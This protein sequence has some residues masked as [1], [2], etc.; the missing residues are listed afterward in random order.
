[1][2]RVAV[3][4]RPAGVPF[5]A[6]WVHHFG[7]GSSPWRHPRWHEIFFALFIEDVHTCLPDSDPFRNS[8]SQW[9]HD[10]LARFLLYKPVLLSRVDTTELASELRPLVLDSLLQS[11]PVS[12]PDD[13]DS[14]GRV[15]P[16]GVGEELGDED[17]GS[18][19]ASSD[20]DSGCENAEAELQRLLK[21]SYAAGVT[22]GGL[23]YKHSLED[24][25]QW[26]SGAP[27]QPCLSC[28]FTPTTSSAAYEYRSI[29]SRFMHALQVLSHTG[30][31]PLSRGG[32]FCGIYWSTNPSR[33][34]QS[35]LWMTGR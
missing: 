34:S 6:F 19:D 1:M 31:A 18:E 22:A 33:R 17:P 29:D 14:P 25:F 21:A 26:A 11:F 10:T 5:P 3:H 32:R 16:P 4:P 30:L 7:W 2:R 12:E 24:L 23:L 20:E 28:R 35:P 9:T 8:V 13:R 15:G 27:G